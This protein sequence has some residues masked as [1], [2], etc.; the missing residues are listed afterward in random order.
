VI[1]DFKKLKLRNWNQIVKDRKA[2]NDM[3][4]ETYTPSGLQRQKKNKKNIVSFM[5]PSRRNCSP[6]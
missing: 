3:M 2:L 5:T 1:N 6:S 4:Q